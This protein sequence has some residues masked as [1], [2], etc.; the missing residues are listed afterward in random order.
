MDS[1]GKVLRAIGFIILGCAAMC[2]PGFAQA[3]VPDS[4]IIEQ[5][6]DTMLRKLT[7]EQK[8]DLI[9]G[10]DSMY[11]RKE[12]EI[13][14]PRLK[15]SDGPVG[16]RTWGPST[17]Y[18]AGVALAASWDPALAKRVGVSLGEDARARGVNFLL[19][20]GVNI[21]RAPMDGRNFEYFGED[22]Y[23]ASRMAVGY[24]DGVQSQG[25]IAT[26]KHFALNNQE[27]DRHNV[28]S[29]A[30]ERTMREIYLPAFEA[31]VREAHVGAVMNSYNLINGSHATQNAWL[32][33][34]VLKKEWGFNGILMSDWAATY[35][36]VAAAQNGLD[37]EMP[38]AEFMNRKELLPAIQQGI[39]STTEIDDKVRRILRTAIRFG[40]LEREQQDTELSRYNEQGN[41]T[42]LEEARESIVL[43]K[44]EGHVLPL[45]PHTTRTIA[46]IGPDAWPAV[47]GGGGSSI[48]T[49]YA[50]VSILA[51]LG[52]VPGIK[53]LYSPGLPPIED[54]FSD[55]VFTLTGSG[56]G[57]VKVETFNN[58]TFSGKPS[59]VSY[60]DHIAMWR[61]QV[62]SPDGGIQKSIRYTA[63][64]TPDKS[65]SYLV[66]VGGT[67]SDA[68]KLSVDGK[69]VLNQ[70][71]REAQAPQSTEIQLIQGRPMTV[72]LDYLPGAAAPRVSLGIRAVEDLITPEAKKIA[73]Q[74]DAA[75][76]SVGYDAS[77]E[78]EG[79]DR[80]YALPFGQD[81]LVEA[82]SAA[83]KNTIVT[84]TAGADVDT[85]RWL[86]HAPVLLHTWYSGQAAGAA[87][88]EIVY[89]ERSPEGKLPISFA[90]SWEENPVHDNYYAA[91]VPVGQTPHVRYAEG[92]FLG[93]RY[94][95]TEH[96]EPL[97]PF[98]FGLSYTTFNFGNL[99]ISPSGS[100]S[101][102]DVTVSFNV[103]NTGSVAGADVAQ[104]YVGDPSAKIKR[105]AR[106]LKGFEKVRLQPGQEQRVTLHLNSR[107]LSY[108]DVKGQRW[109]VDPGKFQVFVGDSSE[110][111]P[112]TG[113]FPV[114]P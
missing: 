111:T 51:G 99:K 86:D 74:A 42:A 72:T 55:T 80:P 71:S 96:K 85:H 102:E 103:K 78:G 21:Y 35:D 2:V 19:G 24:V 53:V 10:Q 79:F 26:V 106:E 98:G 94:Y 43:L 107:T 108:W 13:G 87:L 39:I 67:A 47:P 73:S 89:G 82:V 9:G 54:I 70:S 41:Q 62:W 76:V 14:L 29:D 34:Q 50:D 33:M 64:Y 113:E 75:I 84:L 7:L 91:K 18:T 44:N 59:S 105:P 104:L 40:F 15:M 95:T 69:Q 25:V 6:V 49:P 66:A 27:Y 97:Y 81:A 36:G 12:P 61:P 1:Y 114:A 60:S 109:R 110:N 83:N 90:R 92:V 52:A 101:S 45:N 11:I 100:T 4:P 23:L 88:A 63:R 5:R 3:P 28:S 31:A 8:I 56:A 38:R 32:N 77:T 48:V 16:V 22:P 112:L 57:A 68:Y 37:L 93:Y 58:R 65:G 20:P 46:V 17:A 30:D